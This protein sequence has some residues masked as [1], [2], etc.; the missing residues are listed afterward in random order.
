MKNELLIIPDVHGRSFWRSA[1]YG[2]EYDHVIFLGDYMDPY[3]YYEMIS[4]REAYNE[5]LAI[6]KYKLEHPKDCTLLLGNHDLHYLWPDRECSR[7]ND[8][9]GDFLHDIYEMFLDQFLLAYEV[10]AMGKKILFSH[11]GILK[12]WLDDCHMRFSLNDYNELMNQGSFGRL[13]KISHYRGGYD[14]FGS[15][16]WADYREHQHSEPLQGYYQIFG[17]TLL[18]RPMVTDHW[19]CL[20]CMKAFALSKETG[21]LRMIE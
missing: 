8:R 13:W 9:Q 16:V 11:A 19:A 6:L 3:M 15:P 20:D 14:T 7:R 21:V 10:D 5:F 2:D 1:V 18:E 12:G 4:E 17:H